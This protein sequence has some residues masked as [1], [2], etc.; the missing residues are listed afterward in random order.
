MRHFTL[1]LL[2]GSSTLATPAFASDCEISISANDAM[3]FSA[4]ELTVPASCK[5]V[6]LTL[7]HTGTLPKT[8][9]GHNWVLTKAAD[10]QAVATDGMAAGPDAAY[11]KADDTRVL[12]HTA[13]VGGGESTSVSFSL[14]GLAPAEAYR[15]FCSFPGHWAIMQGSFVITP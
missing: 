4:Q 10:V 13:L 1:A 9:M 7:T 3:Q 8:A 11:I 2:L 6:T 14:E 12:A 5:Q 15:F